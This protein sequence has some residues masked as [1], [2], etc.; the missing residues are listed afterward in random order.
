MEFATQCKS[1]GQLATT[2]SGMPILPDHPSNADRRLALAKIKSQITL[3]KKYIA[4]LEE[5]ADKLEE[6]LALAIYP[7][8]SL[9]TEITSTIFVHCLP[10]HGRVEPSL[11]KAPLLLA[12]I[13][14][15]WRQIALGTCAL[16][17]SVHITPAF[18]V[19]GLFNQAVRFG[20]D[21]RTSGLLQ[22]WLARAKASPLSLGLDF[23]VRA[24]S[25][26]LLDLALS[27]AAQIQQ[28]D[29]R[30]TREQFQELHPLRASFPQLQ[31]LTLDNC[32][33]PELA[34]FLH[35]T[36]SL[37]ELRLLGY[38][39]GF[40]PDLSLPHLTHLEILADISTTTLLR[41]LRDSPLLTT[42]RFS[43]QE[44]DTYPENIG[45]SPT[46][47]TVFP[48]LS[49][50]G[51]D[52]GPAVWALRFL[53]L[54]A[55]REITLPRF[56]E[57]EDVPEFVDRSSCII[58]HLT[59]SF[60][61]QEEGEEDPVGKWLPIFPHVTVL[62]VKECPDVDALLDWLESGEVMPHLE[63]LTFNS[64]LTP[65]TLGQ[66]HD[67]TLIALLHNRRDLPG[68]T[69]LRRL[70][71]RFTLLG[72]RDDEKDQVW[73]PGT[74]AI[75]ELKQLIDAGLDFLF[76]VA[77][78]HNGTLTWPKTYVAPDALPFS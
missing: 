19:Q 65:T 27:F 20:R 35:R 12:Q 14:H 3:Y 46:S 50:L 59:I 29:L 4:A 73:S 21:N 62:D 7:V 71:M 43:L 78:T 33:D 54:P 70:H 39:H 31:D 17:T 60:E 68:C 51:L 66:N 57:P 63:E 6:G 49:S 25:P 58:E 37:R 36:P 72:R 22:T 30:L 5:Q 13:C 40:P 9:P 26:E 16:W 67:D 18:D 77:S 42:L 55:L 69:K 74:L 23:Q 64:D 61:E 24:I 15:D 34:A 76:H 41:L 75:R 1:C 52:S 2:A 38:N 32:T 48:N 47:P 53:T 44:S 10:P 11:S 56:F 28:L 8:L 45:S